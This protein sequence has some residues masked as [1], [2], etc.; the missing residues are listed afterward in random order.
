MWKFLIQ[1]KGLKSKTGFLKEEE[2]L[3]QDYISSS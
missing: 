1:L 3:P 2:I